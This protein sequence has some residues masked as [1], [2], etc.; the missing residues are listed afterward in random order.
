MPRDTDHGK[1]TS[2]QKYLR[3]SF[4]FLPIMGSDPVFSAIS[5]SHKKC[6]MNREGN[7]TDPN[8]QS[9]GV[10][11]ANFINTRTPLNTFGTLAVHSD[12]GAGVDFH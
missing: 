10:R 6:G 3:E 9:A 7:K 8:T 2:S 12:V 4:T 1:E 11:C 5:R